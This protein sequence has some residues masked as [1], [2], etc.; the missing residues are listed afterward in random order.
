MSSPELSICIPTFNR[1]AELKRLLLSIKSPSNF[2]LEIVIVDDGSED[3]TVKTC[4][5]LE[6]TFQTRWFCQKNQGRAA[7]LHL[8][9][10]RARGNYILIM[11]S[12]DYFLEDSIDNIL[13]KLNQHSKLLAQPKICGLV[14]TCLN[15]RM[16]LIGSRFRN[17]EINNFV[18]YLVEEQVSGDKKEI[19]KADYLKKHLYEIIPNERRV[20][21]ST[22]WNRLARNFDVITVN[23]PI[24]IKEYHP[25]GMSKNLTKIRIQSAQSTTNYY[26]E[27]LSDYL[28][29]YKNTWHAFRTSANYVRFS[30]HSKRKIQE[31][32]QIFSFGQKVFLLI[33]Y[34]LGWLLFIRDC[35]FMRVNK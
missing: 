10:S 11:D 21:T 14:F 7:A 3:G 16:E 17:E 13:K 9:I 19:I 15:E 5:S 22:I 2:K 12:D 31:R 24:V 33:S 1:C 26:E 35:A 20:A 34:P 8:A 4:V 18:K 6:L 28:K 25:N 29:T 30:L 32:T 27:H 23:V